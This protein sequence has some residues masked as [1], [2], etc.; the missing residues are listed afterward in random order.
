M[1]SIL[2][3][4]QFGTIKPW[5]D[6]HDADCQQNFNVRADCSCKRIVNRKAYRVVRVND[7][8]VSHGIRPRF[9]AEIW[10]D[11]RLV[12]REQGRKLRVE[13]TLGAVYEGCLM[14]EARRA[15]AVKQAARK[16]R[17]LERKAK[18]K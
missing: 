8:S 7:R 10:P 5:H 2:H 15:M 16:A 6:P 12:I 14:R 3:P 17:R 9:V 11:G 18:R 13:T 4:D 1:D